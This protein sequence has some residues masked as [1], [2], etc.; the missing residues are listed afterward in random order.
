VSG[1]LMIDRYNT[2]IGEFREKTGD[3]LLTCYR[4]LRKDGKYRRRLDWQLARG[5][6]ESV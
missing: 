1:Q 2:F 4:G 5:I 6:I 3:V